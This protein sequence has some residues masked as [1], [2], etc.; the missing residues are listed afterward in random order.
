M[1]KLTSTFQKA[2]YRFPHDLR[3]GYI[4]TTRLLHTILDL[5]IED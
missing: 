5:L 3:Y 1:V 2:P 4:A